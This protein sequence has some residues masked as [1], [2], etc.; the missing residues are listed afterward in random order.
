MIN[1]FG[2]FKL[3]LIQNIS[4]CFVQ[5]KLVF[6]DLRMQINVNVTDFLFKCQIQRKINLKKR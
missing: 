2:Y 6:L 4:G 3:I 5:V 1:V